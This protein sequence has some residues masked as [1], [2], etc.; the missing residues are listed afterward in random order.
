MKDQDPDD[1]SLASMLEL[2]RLEAENQ[3]AVITAGLLEL[4]RS[5]LSGPQLEALMRAAHSLKGAAQIVDLEAAVSVA[6]AMEDCFVAWRSRREF[7]CA[8]MKLT[9]C[10]AAWTC[11]CKFRRTPA[12]ATPIGSGSTR[13]SFAACWRKWRRWFPAAA[14]PSPAVPASRER[15]RRPAP[16]R[17]M[18]TDGDDRSGRGKLERSPPGAITC[19]HQPARKTR[20][21]WCGWPPAPW[22]ECWDWLASHWLNPAGSIPLPIP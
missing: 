10:S 14:D 5:P 18:I 19:H 3:T 2:F 13:S 15:K 12:P 20:I 9:P 11:C 6:H 1:L 7:N 17:T 8:R 4:E 16:R 21:G 22:T